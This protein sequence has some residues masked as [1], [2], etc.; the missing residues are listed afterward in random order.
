M[1]ETHAASGVCGASRG[2]SMFMKVEVDN[3]VEFGRLSDK[4]C[5]GTAQ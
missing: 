3:A 5:G 1:V 2:M 4:L